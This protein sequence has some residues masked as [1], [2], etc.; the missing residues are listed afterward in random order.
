MSDAFRMGFVPMKAGDPTVS[1]DT[2]IPLPR[3]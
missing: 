1:N 3:E 2:G